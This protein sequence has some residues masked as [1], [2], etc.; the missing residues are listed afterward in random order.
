VAATVRPFLLT[1]A[2]SG[3]LAAAMPGGQAQEPGAIGGH[4]KLTARV[5]SSRQPSA[6][7]ATRGVPRHDPPP[8][9]EIRNVVV[10]LKGVAFHGALPITTG[11]MRQ[12]HETF[13]PHVL[14]IT[15]GS[16]VSF[17]NGDPIFHNVFSLSRAATFDL[18]RYPE[19]H[20]RAEKFPDAGLV[21]VYC[22]IHSHMSAAILVL[23]HPYFATPAD[24][25]TFR[26]PEV[27]SGAYT[28]VGWHERVGERA[29]AIRVEPGRQTDVELTLPVE[30]P[31]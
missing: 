13:V 3:A 8:M 11:E 29:V 12:E 16:T 6:I 27:P 21:K 4:V 20:S 7:Y 23:D 30:D 24:D 26:L 28:I 14:A 18:G 17:P 19:G 10:Y 22:R 15:R 31:Q 25:G 9:P 1:I 2:I 5:R